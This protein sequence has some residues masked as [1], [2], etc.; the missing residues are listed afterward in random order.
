MLSK[1]EETS[2]DPSGAISFLKSAALF[3]SAPAKDRKWADLSVHSRNW[4]TVTAS[5]SN[6]PGAT[7]TIRRRPRIVAPAPL[8]FALPSSFLVT[9]QP[10][11]EMYPAAAVFKYA[12]FSLIPFPALSGRYGSISNPCLYVPDTVVL[13]PACRVAASP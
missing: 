2:V 3:W 1:F 11:T 13:V 12:S 5:V 7:L 8:A 10:P 9:S 4:A 6:A